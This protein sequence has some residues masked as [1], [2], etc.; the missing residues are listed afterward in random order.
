MLGNTASSSSVLLKQHFP[1][2]SLPSHPAGTQP[3]PEEQSPL[4]TGPAAAY[5]AG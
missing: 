5:A 4:T 1:S 3:L 2:L